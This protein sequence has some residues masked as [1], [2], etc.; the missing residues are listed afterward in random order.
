MATMNIN[1][2]PL[3]WVVY[4]AARMVFAIMQSF[5]INWNLRTARLIVPWW[6]RL[7]PRHLERAR[8]HLNAAYGQ[9]LTPAEADRIARKSLE[10]LAMFVVETICLPRLMTPHTWPKYIDVEDCQECLRLA[11]NGRGVIM[12]TGHYGSFELLA[13]LLAA[14]GCQMVAIMRPLDNEYLNEF[15]VK[16]RRMHGLELL[17]KKGAMS[18]SESIIREGRVLGFIGDQDAG[19]K[20]CFVDFFGQP[21]ST[22]KSIGLLAMSTRCP[23]VV[24]CAR[25]CGNVARYDFV[26]QRIIHPHEWEDRDDPLRWITQAYTSAIEDFSRVAPEQYLWIHRRWKSKPRARRGRAGSPGQSEVQEPTAHGSMSV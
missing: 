16:S 3:A 1:R 13:Q 7:M 8:A 26:V 6:I 4:I 18:Q 25:R 10:S 5:P 11:I 23:I 17:D 24:A 2:G 9:S 15:L 14:L 19:R 20:G 12:V 22:Y 21:A